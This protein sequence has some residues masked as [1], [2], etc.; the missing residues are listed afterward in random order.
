MRSIFAILLLLIGSP[1]IYAQSVCDL[2]T[3]DLP[4]IHGVR[5]GTTRKDFDFVYASSSDKTEP[6]TSTELDLSHVEEI[7]TGFYHDRLARV[8]FDYDRET[9]WKNVRQFAE[10]LDRKVKL[11]YDSWVFVGNT[12]AVMECRDFRAS[13]S[14]VRNTLSLTDTLAKTAAE[15]EARRLPEMTRQRIH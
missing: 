8:E 13:I 10:H 6:S 3:A 7:W 14:S 15:Q 9:D 12:E 5:L 1:G 11:P 4:A 2:T